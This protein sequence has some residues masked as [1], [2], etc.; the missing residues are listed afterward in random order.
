M[1]LEW[2]NAFVS[3][4]TLAIISISAI[5]A[6]I[7]VRHARA[8]NGLKAVLSLQQEFRSKAVQ[9]ALRYV[10][11]DLPERLHDPAYR[12]ELYELGFIDPVEHPEVTACNWFDEM[13]SVVKNRMVAEDAFMDLFGRLLAHYWTLLSPAIA[14]MR[15]RRGQSQYHNFEYV[16]THARRWIAQH[17]AGIFPHGTDRV[18]LADPWLPMDDSGVT[19][20]G[21]RRATPPNP[22]PAP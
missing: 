5:A 12:R 9:E 17:P 19:A 13:G 4:I 3:T 1:H 16:A 2:F 22:L 21:E 7:S 14:L 18:P 11:R 6:L 20:D 10:Q 8:S 15:R